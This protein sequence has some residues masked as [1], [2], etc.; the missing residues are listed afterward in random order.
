MQYQYRRCQYRPHMP[1]N[2]KLLTVRDYSRLL[3][4]IGIAS[5]VHHDSSRIERPSSPPPHPPPWPPPLSARR[6]YARSSHLPPPAQ[7]AQSSRHDSSSNAPSSKHR[8]ADRS[9]LLSH[10]SF[11]VVSTTQRLCLNPIL[12]MVATTGVWR[13][14]TNRIWIDMWKCLLMIM[15]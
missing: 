3:G 7:L 8:L 10:R 5:Q 4:H 15:M 9:S 13:G 12:A 2:H 11:V 1:A 6:L 14:A